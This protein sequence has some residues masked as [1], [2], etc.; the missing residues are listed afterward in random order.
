MLTFGARISLRSAGGGYLAI[1]HP[2]ELIAT[3]SADAAG[4]RFTLV[5]PEDADSREAV[6]YNVDVA[7][8]AE[9]GRYLTGR[10][11]GVARARTT[12][13]NAFQRWRLEDPEDEDASGPVDLSRPLALRRR[14]YLGPEKDG[15]VSADRIHPRAEFTWTGALVGGVAEGRAG[16]TGEGAVLMPHTLL[17]QRL[18]LAEGLRA[19]HV[20][21]FGFDAGGQ[22]RA[23]VYADAGGVPGVLL[24]ETAAAALDPGAE[25]LALLAPVDLPAGD[26]HLAVQVD[27][28]ARLGQSSGEAAPTQVRA[29]AFSDPLPSPFDAES[30]FSG[31]ALTLNLIGD[32]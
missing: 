7:L 10:S 22:L 3:A 20:G 30:S 6:H 16:D 11:D 25:S 12:E 2:G 13:L 5:D 24:A 31:P 1:V 28:L 29:L 4:T 27:Q 15:T 14:G 32:R 19:T 18:H 26:L 21:F 17:S 8:L 23:A 9:N